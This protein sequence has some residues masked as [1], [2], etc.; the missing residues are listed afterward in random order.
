VGLG[1]SAFGFRRK[2]F[3]P[4]AVVP[5]YS[6]RNPYLLGLV[7][8]IGPVDCVDNPC[9][10]RRRGQSSVDDP[11]TGLVDNSAFLCSNVHHPQDGFSEGTVT[12]RLR[13]VI[14]TLF[15]LNAQACS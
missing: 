3:V 10:C 1:L 15:S 5:R 8:V 11:W 14:H 4:R 12:H 2:V 9:P 6:E 13:G 7:I